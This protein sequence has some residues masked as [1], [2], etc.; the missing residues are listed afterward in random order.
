MKF[1]WSRQ[2]KIIWYQIDIIDSCSRFKSTET[3]FA[4]YSKLEIYLF[5]VLCLFGAKH[6]FMNLFSVNVIF[7]F[8]IEWM[9]QNSNGGGL[10]TGWHYRCVC[11][12]PNNAMMPPLLRTTTILCQCEIFKNLFNPV[13]FSSHNQH[14][15]GW[16]LRATQSHSISSICVSID[17]RFHCMFASGSIGSGW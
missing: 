16:N 9:K 2:L 1:F 6:F 15:K 12:D 4:R 10:L 7:L 13:T 11:V 8:S 17:E 14:T 3:N 5:Y